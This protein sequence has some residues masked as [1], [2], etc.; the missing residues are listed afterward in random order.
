MTAKT[1]LTATASVA[2]LL[3]AGCGAVRYPTYYAL[4]VAPAP[5]LTAAWTMR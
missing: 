1:L 3:T 4:D 2:A 5:K